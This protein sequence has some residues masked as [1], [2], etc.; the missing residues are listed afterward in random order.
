MCRTYN[1]HGGNKIVH[2]IFVGKPEEERPLGRPMRKLNDNG[3]DSND[4]G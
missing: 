3:L 1:T 4:S 2:I